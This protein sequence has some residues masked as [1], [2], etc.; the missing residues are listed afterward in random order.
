LKSRRKQ[1]AITGNRVG[2]AHLSKVLPAKAF[3][4]KRPALVPAVLAWRQARHAGI[5]RSRGNAA[6]GL[7][8]SIALA[9]PEHIVVRTDRGRQ[10]SSRRRPLGVITSGNPGHGGSRPARDVANGR[11]FSHSRDVAA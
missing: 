5:G 3:A 7:R 10:E 8:Y 6:D 2:Y 4:L 1:E 9:A 11:R